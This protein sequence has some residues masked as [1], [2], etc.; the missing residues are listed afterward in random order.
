[1]EIITL[2]LIGI[3]SRLV[4]HLPNVTPVG[5]TALFSS[6]KFGIKKGLVILLLTMLITDVLI[7]LHPVMWATYGSFMITLCIG[8]WVQKHYSLSRFMIGTIVS[9]VLFFIIT[10]FAVWLV[11]NGMYA[12][13][14]TG[15]IHCYIMALPFFRNSLI[16]DFSYGLVF[17]Y[18]YELVRYWS[19]R[20]L[21]SISQP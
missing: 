2:T 12:K 10:N 9:S 17:Y 15:L 3:I 1:M 5:A 13:T 11:P 16:G 21:R 20:T 7:G 4:P 18:G 19:H 6:A 8:W 14:L